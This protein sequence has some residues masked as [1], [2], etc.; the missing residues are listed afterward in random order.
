MNDQG[1]TRKKVSAQ[2]FVSSVAL[3]IGILLISASWYQNGKILL[4]LGIF[5]T[6][7]GVLAGVLSLLIYRKP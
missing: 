6:G 5:I 7:G 3:L 4:Y 2:T 1:T